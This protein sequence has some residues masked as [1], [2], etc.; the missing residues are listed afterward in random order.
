MLV[1]K[2]ENI[3]KL[4]ESD[5]NIESRNISYDTSMPAEK[6]RTYNLVNS[7]TTEYKILKISSEKDFVAEFRL[8]I[9]S[10]DVGYIQSIRVEDSFQGRSIGS[11][12][13][14]YILNLL[15]GVVDVVYIYPTNKP[16]KIICKKYGFNTVDNPEGWYMK[17]LS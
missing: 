1:S 3:S 7:T 16:M 17:R 9:I 4:I 10:S 12:I 8:C 15:T 11:E 14:N 5:V 13:M 6:L 2:N